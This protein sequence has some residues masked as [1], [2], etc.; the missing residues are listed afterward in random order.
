MILRNPEWLGLLPVLLVAGWLLPRLNLFR[1]LRLVLLVL[2]TLVMARPQWRLVAD[3][4]DLWVLAD[5][6]VSAKEPMGKQLPELEKLLEQSRGPADRLFYLN[7]AD[8]V[9]RRGM[10]GAALYERSRHQTRIALAVTQALAYAQR[11]SQGRPAR[12]LVLSDGYS[13]EPLAGVADKLAAQGVGLDYRLVRERQVEDYRV[14]SLRTPVEVQ[15]GEPFLLEVEVRGTQ[16]GTVPLVITRNGRE[17]SQTDVELALGRGVIKLTDRIAFPGVARY[18]ARVRPAADAHPGNNAHTTLVEARGGPRVLLLTAYEDDPLPEVLQRQGFSVE[19]IRELTNLSARRIAGAK[20]VIFNNVPAYELPSDF[21]AALDFYV[22]EQG[23]SVMMAGGKRSFGAGGYFESPLDPLL[24]VSMEMKEEHRKLRVAMAIVMDRSGSMAMSVQNGFTKMSLANEGAGNAIQFLSAQDLLSVFAVD[25]EAHV[26]VPLQEV[27]P[28]REKMSSA[29]RRIESMGGGIFVYNGLE[30]AWKQLKEAPAGQRHIILFSDAADSEQPGKYRQ[31][32]KEM[33]E[34]GTTVSVIALGTRSDPDAGFLED[35]AK[36][37]DGRLFFT[38]KAEELPSIFSQETV[39]VARSAFVTD[40]VGTQ[41]AGGWL[42][43]SAKSFDWLGEVDGYNLSYLRDWASQALLTKDEYAA[44]LVAFGQRGLGRTA[45]VSFPLGGEYSDRVRGWDRYGDLVQ[46]LVRW[47]SGDEVPPGLGLRHRMEGNTLALDLLYE[48][49]WE[50]RMSGE[51]PR[52]LLARGANADES[53]EVAWERLAPGH[54]QSRVELADGESVRGAVQVKN[55]ALTFGPVM[56]GRSAEWAF[57]DARV[58]ELRAVSAASGG[59]ELL[60]MS[61]AWRTV[62]VVKFTDLGPWILTA[63]LVLMLVEALF[64]RAGWRMP[65]L[66]LKPRARR[67]VLEPASD[68]LKKLR[69]TEERREGSKA[70]SGASVSKGPPPEPT[71]TRE[72]RRQRFAR[73]KRK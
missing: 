69:K 56:A 50:E 6:S 66:A 15:I 14:A 1:P 47:L 17:V 67:P 33:V 26:V 30:A 49:E 64:T 19:V 22:R 40:P 3:G 34:N 71:T 62:P 4:V 73:A 11:D 12:V 2:L 24:P 42:E 59:R 10:E 39:A 37:G 29:V 61:Q 57:D 8:E 46:T 53:Q 63:L 52:V 60:E 18:E 27:G 36:R 9:M 58:E 23:G 44:P 54:Y 68:Y 32:L 43:I 25:S 55:H 45:A 38:D 65:E 41:A 21:L 13:T 70:K 35:I 5:A 28:N 51:A 31:L 20:C 48:P 72:E 16:D 7:F